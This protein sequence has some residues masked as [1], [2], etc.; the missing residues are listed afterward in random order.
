MTSAASAIAPTVVPIGTLKNSRLVFLDVLRGLAVGGMIL[1]TDPGTYNA[2]GVAIT[3]SFAS[4]IEQGS[5]RLSF[6]RHVVLRSD[7]KPEN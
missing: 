4:R 3:L 1:V 7:P 2:V 6:A 5:D